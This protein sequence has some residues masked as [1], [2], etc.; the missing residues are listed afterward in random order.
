MRSPA[1]RA[2]TAQRRPRPI[3]PHQH[4]EYHQL[5]L[6]RGETVCLL[7]VRRIGFTEEDLE[8][9]RREKGDEGLGEVEGS[10]DLKG[11]GGIGE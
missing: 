11:F 9:Y 1:E 4:E 6:R 10:R 8:R 3:L 5:L 7:C 2:Q